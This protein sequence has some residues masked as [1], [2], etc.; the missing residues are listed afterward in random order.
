MH[1][2]AWKT[3]F[4]GWGSISMKLRLSSLLRTSCLGLLL[5]CGSPGRLLAQP[6]EGRPGHTSYQRL[7]DDPSELQPGAEE[8]VRS[9]LE[10][11]KALQNLRDNPAALEQQRK[12][13]EDLKLSPE[14]I[15]KLKKLATQQ[16]ANG[17]PQMQKL[18]EEIQKDGRTPKELDEQQKEMLHKMLEDSSSTPTTDSSSSSKPP[19]TP[20]T[21]TQAQ[22]PPS[23]EPGEPGS[24][25]WWNDVQGQAADWARENMADAGKELVSAIDRIESR[26]GKNGVNDWFGSLDVSESGLRYRVAEQAQGLSGYFP[27]LN[28]RLPGMENPLGP[29]RSLWGDVSLPSLPQGG[30]PS[31]PKGEAA[32]A[33][34][35]LSFALVFG[36]AGVLVL[37]LVARYLSQRRNALAE[38]ESER[39]GPWPIAPGA[40]STREQLVRAFEYLALL[41]L[42]RRARSSHHLEVAAQLGQKGGDLAHE[43][44]AESL[45][46]LYEQARYAPTWEQLGPDQLQAARRH[47]CFLA[48]VQ[49]S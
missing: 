5:V 6:A 13:L 19:E 42:G 14:Q 10:A 28:G 4:L 31:L 2:S 48:G 47:L 25:S 7:E 26:A 36:L 49:A 11:L 30:R 18:L 41:T 23:G 20:A 27:R 17:S 46:R 29:I 35:D 39:L 24:E 40:V 8:L 21:S 22:A 32:A 38:E 33:A 43:Q 45:A 1:S 3:P 44:A 12:R 34:G 37:V 16:G 15:E 9:R